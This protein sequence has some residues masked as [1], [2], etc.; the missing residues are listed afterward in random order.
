M[1]DRQIQD[2]L[3]WM[4][5]AGYAPWTMAQH[6]QIL[7]RLLD[8]V[9][10]NSIPW[11]RTFARDTLQA[12]KDH[13]QVKYA[14]F[15]L[16]GFMRYLHQNGIICLPPGALPEGRGR[17]KL[18]RA[19]L[20][21][22]YEEYL[23]FYTQTRQVGHVQIYRVRGTLSAL[24]D[25][26][27]NQGMELKDLDV[28]HMDAFLAERNR[29]YAPETRIHE[30]SGLRGFLRYLYLERQILKKDLS[31]LIQGPPVYAQ[32]RPPRFLTLEQIKTLFQSI[33]KDRPGGLRSYA[34]IHLAYSLGLRPGEICRVTL[35]DILFRDK[36]IYLPDRKNSSPAK[37]PLPQGALRALAAY[38]AWDRPMDPGHRFL[39]CNTRT[40]YGPLTPLTV[41]QNISACFRRA[42]IKGSAYWLRHTYAQNLLQAEASIFEIKE[43]LGHDIIKTSKRYLHVH[44][45]LMREVLFNEKV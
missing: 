6:S 38:L 45:R 9:V 29:K 8:F 27:Q 23:Q 17:S 36:L 10:L 33:D 28:L 43:M 16:R 25:Y 37:L 42:G 1:L 44:T 19:Q 18:Q 40:P 2:Y 32:S 41:S 30:R 12:F 39:L 3:E 7:N 4:N 15:V 35:D 13:V 20:P 26:L 31:A 22:L 21:R 14:G 34:M 5:N 24:N 11:E